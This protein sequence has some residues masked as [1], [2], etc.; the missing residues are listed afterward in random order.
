MEQYRMDIYAN[1]EL[2]CSFTDARYVLQHL[3][4]NL[5]GRFIDNDGFVERII[6]RTSKKDSIRRITVLTKNGIKIVYS[7]PYASES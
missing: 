5:A 3:K 4:Q 1:D 2:C 6:E 7:L